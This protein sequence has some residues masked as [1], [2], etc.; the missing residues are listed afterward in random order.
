M[1]GTSN[2][3]PRI[4]LRVV[5]TLIVLGVPAVVAAAPPVLTVPGAQTVN[6]NELLTFTVSASDP[7]GQTCDMLVS[8]RPSGATFRDN[9]N[10]TGT[11]TW[12]P[13]PSQV[14]TYVV[15]F[16]AD[17]TF[18][19]IDMESVSVEVR[20][21]NAVPVLNPIADRSVERGGFLALLATGSDDD[22]D[23]LSFRATGMPS[24]G[25]LTDNGDGSA[26]LVFTPGTS[27]PLGA[28]TITVFLS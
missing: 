9:G 19:G 13:T 23:A 18:G 16:T 8:S 4:A 1:N 12:T 3:L 20:S 6:E 17:D 2:P 7:D 26:S 14:G 15:T 22:G 25:T 24:F 27:A 21:V 28:T 10:N 11:F 5:L